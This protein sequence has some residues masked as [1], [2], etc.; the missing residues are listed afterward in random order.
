MEKRFK[1][2]PALVALFND[3]PLAP[4]Y[5]DHPLKGEMKGHILFDLLLLY[6]YDNDDVLYLEAL[7][8]HSEA[9]GL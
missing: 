2:K 9:L 1:P 5:Y 4:S 3:E 6:R 7:N 8:T